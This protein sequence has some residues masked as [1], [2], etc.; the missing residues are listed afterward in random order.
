M[1]DEIC[2]S[3]VEFVVITA[4]KD[5]SDDTP[6]SNVEIYCRKKHW[7]IDQFNDTED[8]YEQKMSSAKDCKDYTRR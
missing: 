8:D 2:L 5:Y 7:R 6:G 1:P 3:C 4:E